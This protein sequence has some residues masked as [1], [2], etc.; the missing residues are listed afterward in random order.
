MNG[1]VI[2]PNPLDPSAGVSDVPSCNAGVCAFP[3][4]MARRNSARVPNVWNVNMGVY[5]NFSLT[6]RFKLQLRGEAYNLFNHSNYYVNYG[7]TDM[8]NGGAVSVNKG[9][10]TERRN[11]QLAIRLSF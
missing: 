8:E 3:S 2:I 4:N 1:V 11:M 9:N 10:G 7:D 6:E 5:K